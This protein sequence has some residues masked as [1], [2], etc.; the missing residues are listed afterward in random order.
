VTRRP[1]F[2][3]WALINV[4]YAVALTAGA[5]AY[6]GHVATAGKLGVAAVLACYAAGSL[7]AGALLWR[8]DT[9]RQPQPSELLVLEHG[10]VMLPAVAMLGMVAGLL[11]ALSG[12]DGDIGQRL[13]GASTTM[14]STFTGIA[15]FLVLGVQ[16]L[17]LRASGHAAR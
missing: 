6:N 13:A 11:I 12:I 4:L 16:D 17:L 5:V 8:L 10:V 14:V 7:F 15:S 9:G 3:A 1:W 2:L